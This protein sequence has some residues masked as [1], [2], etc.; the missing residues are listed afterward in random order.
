MPCDRMRTGRH[1]KAASNGGNDMTSKLLQT[2]ALGAVLALGFGLGS[3]S[4]QDKVL[5]G[6]ITK[7]NTNPFFAKMKEGADAKAKEL[8]VTLQAFAGK[9][10]GDNDAQVAA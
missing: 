10:D 9:Y 4:A 5:I 7:T 1:L 6:L 2:A 8:G 3:A